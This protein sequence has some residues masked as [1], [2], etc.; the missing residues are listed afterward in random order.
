M[1]GTSSKAEQDLPPQIRNAPISVS[2]RHAQY[3]SLGE[4]NIL[5]LPP[6]QLF[7]GKGEAIQDTAEM[8]WR[9]VSEAFLA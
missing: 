6:G 9:R 3:Y 7:R 4:N 1:L 2:V 8:R 5:W